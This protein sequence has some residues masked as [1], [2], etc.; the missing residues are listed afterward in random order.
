MI[1]IIVNFDNSRWPYYLLIC[2]KYGGL[3]LARILET[4]AIDVGFHVFD[5]NDYRY[6]LLEPRV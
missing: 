5:D 2:E 1:I 3:R 4:G 6:R